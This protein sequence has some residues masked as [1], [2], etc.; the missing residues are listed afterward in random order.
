MEGDSGWV[1]EDPVLLLVDAESGATLRSFDAEWT[2]GEISR[3]EGDRVLL[4]EGDGTYLMGDVGTG[5]T[6]WRQEL[7][8]VRAREGPLEGV[9]YATIFDDEG[10]REFA[11]LDGDTG[12]ELERVEPSSLVQPH[13]PGRT[14]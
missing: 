4:Y 11:R 10:L 6:L 5:E 9:V 7:D 12:R 2:E 13:V 14:Q 8:D 3:V 1:E